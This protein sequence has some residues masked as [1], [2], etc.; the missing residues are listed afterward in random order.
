MI[1]GD[2]IYLKYG[3]YNLQTGNTLNRTFDST[4]CT[5]FSASANHLFSRNENRATIHNINAGGSGSALCSVMRPGC[6]I[7]IMPAGGVILLPPYSAGCT[8]GNPG[9]LQTTI[10]WLPE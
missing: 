2:D 1:I 7:S 6:Y 10:A 8:C 4:S 9:T 5:D 3:C